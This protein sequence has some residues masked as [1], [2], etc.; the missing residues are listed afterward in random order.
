MIRQSSK[1]QRSLDDFCLE[2]FGGPAGAPAV[3]PYTRADLSLALHAVA[4]L[5]WDGFFSARIDAVNAHAP[6]EGLKMSG[7]TL[8]YD[9]TP[10]EFQTARA[11]VDEADDLSLSLG[12]RVK[13]DGTVTD[14]ATG[15]PAHLA[16]VLPAMRLLAIDGRKWTIGAARDAIVAAEKSTRPIELIVESGDAVHVWQV[17]YHQG[18]R[19]P[20][21]VRN[22]DQPDRLSQIMAARFSGAQAPR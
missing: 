10:N 11:V 20:H 14:V 13:S 17:D 3:R 21:L 1:E 19:Y 4:P 6:L 16:G 15:S 2:F 12:L 5:D 8:A 18:L 22:P 7:W 9:D